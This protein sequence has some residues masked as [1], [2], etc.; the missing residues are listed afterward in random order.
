MALIGKTTEDVYETMLT[1]YRACKD[2]KQGT[3]NALEI[4]EQNR[5]FIEEA[6]TRLVDIDEE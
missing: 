4:Y 2:K 1:A 3:K 5:E 6:K